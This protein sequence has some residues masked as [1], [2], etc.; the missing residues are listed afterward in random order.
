M[1]NL[2]NSPENKSNWYQP[3]WENIE[4]V[5]TNPKLDAY[6][7]VEKYPEF[8]GNVT[9]K[10]ISQCLPLTPIKGLAEMTPEKLGLVLGQKCA[11]IFGLVEFLTSLSKKPDAAKRGREI[12]TNLEQQAKHLPEAA[13]QLEAL[14]VMEMIVAE[15]QKDLPQ[16]QKKLL[17]AFDTALMQPNYQEAVEFFAGFAG[18]IAK[19]GFKGGK[20]VQPTEATDLHLKMFMH[21]QR[22]KKF[23]TVKELRAFLLKNGFTNQTLGDDSRLQKYCTRIGYAP[24]RQKNSSKKKT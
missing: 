17:Q 15:F 3:I 12:K 7:D 6:L 2:N 20:I 4:L 5:N 9:A 8:Q 24:G 11:N 1:S 10:L 22:V 18:G 13:N 14:R 19:Q 21:S 23:R 16:F